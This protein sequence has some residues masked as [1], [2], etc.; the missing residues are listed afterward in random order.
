MKVDGT[1]EK[2][3]VEKL[4][5]SE[6]E[7]Q[8]LVMTP[9]TLQLRYD[10]YDQVDTDTDVTQTDDRADDGV[11]IKRKVTTVTVKLKTTPEEPSST[12]PSAEQVDADQKVAEAPASVAEV[13]VKEPLDLNTAPEPGVVTSQGKD[14]AEV[15][16]PQQSPP[17]LESATRL[18]S[19][20]QREEAELERKP[21][22]DDQST[23]AQSKPS[24]VPVKLTKL[25]PLSKGVAVESDDV[26]RLDQVDRKT[27]GVEERDATRN[28][29]PSL[30]VVRL[31]KLE[32]LSFNGSADQLP[33]FD[34]PRPEQP[35]SEPAGLP[36]S[37]P[38]APSD[39]QLGV[40]GPAPEDMIVPV[41]SAREMRGRP[42]MTAAPLDDDLELLSATVDEAP[43]Q[44]WRG[45]AC[46][47]PSFAG[48]LSKGDKAR[49]DIVSFRVF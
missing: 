15:R 42:V 16:P 2:S 48:Q 22:E 33:R 35:R 47:L 43:V 27:S 25:E 36:P 9:G 45:V 19:E 7:E 6:V 49:L 40:V 46:A 5:G 1:E 13:A 20:V 38:G 21:A 18:D 34:Q 28:G 29:S 39:Q 11:W 4:V 12:L 32:P 24:I 37:A 17:H 23:A 8:V 44:V 14:A 3:T 10:Q 31:T 41:P 26:H 30:S